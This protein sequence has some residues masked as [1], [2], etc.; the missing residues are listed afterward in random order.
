MALG[1]P[2]YGASLLA[3]LGVDTVFGD[4]GPYPETSLEEARARRPDLVIAP[5]EP[6]PF[7][8]RHR[9]ELA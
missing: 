8:E 2:T 6:Y 3:H 7:A 9:N 1:A 5:S 4:D